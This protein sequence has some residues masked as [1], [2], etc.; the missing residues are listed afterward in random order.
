[1]NGSAESGYDSAR[2]QEEQED[3]LQVRIDIKNLSPVLPEHSGSYFFPSFSLFF[4]LWKKCFFLVISGIL[5]NIWDL[6]QKHNM[7]LKKG[8]EQLVV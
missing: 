4:F 8:S 6:L 3:N 1:M 5:K 2:G 7:C